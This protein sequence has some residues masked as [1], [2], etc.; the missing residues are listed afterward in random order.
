MRLAV[1][2]AFGRQ[3]DEPRREVDLRPLQAAD[4][5]SPIGMTSSTIA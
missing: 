1:L 4:L 3:L 2:D 5:L